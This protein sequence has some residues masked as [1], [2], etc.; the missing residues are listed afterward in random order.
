MNA[1]TTILDVFTSC[2]RAV[3][4]GKLIVR[5]S[6]GDKEFHFQNWFKER[7]TETGFNFEQGGRNSYPDFTI[8]QVT[9]GYELKGL[10][11]PGRDASFDSNRTNAAG[12]ATFSTT[13]GS[14]RSIAQAVP[15]RLTFSRRASSAATPF[16]TEGR[17]FASC[18]PLAATFSRA[19]RT[20]RP[21]RA[22]RVNAASTR[23]RGAPTARGR[24]VPPVGTRSR[25]WTPF[26]R[27][28]AR[29]DI[30]SS[31]SWC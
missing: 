15:N 31:A 24:R 23:K 3:R 1:S 26:A 29:P 20:R 18:A 25:S 8:V 14:S 6:S 12:Y 2:V 7:L 10:A 17:K 9:D 5:E 4:N 22:P 30:G 21:P 28:A 16:R 11:Y 27:R 19:R 13:S